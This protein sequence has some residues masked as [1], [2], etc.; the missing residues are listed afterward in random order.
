MGYG[1]FDRRIPLPSGDT[2]QVRGP[3]DP[4]DHEVNEGHVLYLVIQGSG[5][6][7]VVCKGLG[8]WQR[9]ENNDDWM[10]QMS[11]WGEKPDGGSGEIQTGVARGIALAVVVR[12]GKLFRDDAPGSTSG[13][14]MIFDPPQVEGVTWCADFTFT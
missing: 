14:T 13:P 7:S 10:G 8:L 3:F 6:D 1:R 11:R 2:V 12:P 5:A 9:G 4:E